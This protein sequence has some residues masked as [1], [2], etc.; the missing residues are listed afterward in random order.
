MKTIV[1]QFGIF[2]YFP[3]QFGSEICNFAYSLKTGNFSRCVALRAVFLV[4][5]YTCK[6]A[7]GFHILLSASISDSDNEVSAFPQGLVI[8]AFR[9]HLLVFFMYNCTCFAYTSRAIKF[10]RIRNIVRPFNDVAH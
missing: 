7:S 5:F 9:H 8:R 1:W 10:D 4:I 6:T 3:G 2:Q